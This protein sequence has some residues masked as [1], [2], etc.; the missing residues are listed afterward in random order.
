MCSLLIQNL[1]YFDCYIRQNLHMNASNSGMFRC[2]K[3]C[4]V[5]GSDYNFLK[6]CQTAAVLL[7]LIICF[8]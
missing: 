5:S 6:V 2:S 4:F 1:K 3:V 8:R 7:H